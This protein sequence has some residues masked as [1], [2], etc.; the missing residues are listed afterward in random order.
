[1]RARERLRIEATHD[2]LTG[3][4]NRAAF[5]DGFARKS[6]RARRY[7]TRWR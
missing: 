4:L 3:L 6:C 7:H 2:S 1:L 5:F